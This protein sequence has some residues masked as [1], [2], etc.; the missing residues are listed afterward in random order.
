MRV[1]ENAFMNSNNGHGTPEQA[2]SRDQFDEGLLRHVDRYIRNLHDLRLYLRGF[3]HG[4]GRLD[5][6][7][8]S[9]D[10]EESLAMAESLMSAYKRN[11]PKRGK[12]RPTAPSS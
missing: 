3:S 6:P 1:I 2:A 7:I 4:G 8:E 11:Y 12:S 5:V 9:G 10:L